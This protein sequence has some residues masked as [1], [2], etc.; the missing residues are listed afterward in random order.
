MRWSVLL[1]LVGC[2]SPQ[3][4]D[5][6]F[7]AVGIDADGAVRGYVEARDLTTTNRQAIDRYEGLRIISGDGREFLIE[8]AREIDP[9]GM[10]S[11]FAGTKPFQVEL[12]L[13]RGRR[14]SETEAVAAVAAA[15]RAHPAHLDLTPHGGAAIADE[16]ARK[17]TVGEIAT[18]LATTY[19]PN[20]VAA[21]AIERG[22]RRVEELAK[23]GE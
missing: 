4:K 10:L 1:L 7:P 14:L 5:I 6:V 23:R 22:N 20:R 3:V 13:K 12:T 2:S 16:M 18:L 9:P 19:E 15:I 11:D 8:S 17:R 21:E